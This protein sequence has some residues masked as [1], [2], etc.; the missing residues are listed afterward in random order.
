MLRTTLFLSLLCGCGLHRSYHPPPLEA[1]AR[2]VR[3]VG[4]VE[5]AF[6]LRFIG[7]HDGAP[8]LTLLLRNEGTS[9]VAF[10]LAR[11]RIEGYS[12]KGSRVLQLDDPRGEVEPMHI[13]PGAWGRE[14]IRLTDLDHESGRLARVCIDVARAFTESSANLAPVC[15]VPTGDATWAVSP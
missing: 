15:F 1:E 10:D 5:V 12:G 8:L 2:T 7:S 11:V 13:D 3:R 14:K 4:D 6:G 9:S